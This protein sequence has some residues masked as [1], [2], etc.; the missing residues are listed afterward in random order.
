MPTLIQLVES[1]AG[2]L[3]VLVGPGMPPVADLQRVGI[4]RLSVGSEI[5]RATLAVARDA[6]DELLQKGTYQTFLDRNIPYH[7]VYELMK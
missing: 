1:V 6:A 4:A 7:E 3:N 5:M 2:P